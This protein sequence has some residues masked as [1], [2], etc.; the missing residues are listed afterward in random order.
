[1]DGA[2]LTPTPTSPAMMGAG[3]TNHVS[4]P[5]LGFPSG[6][7][8][9]FSSS[10]SV[11]AVSS[12]AATTGTNSVPFASVA[13]AAAALLSFLLLP[14]LLLLLVNISL[15]LPFRCHPPS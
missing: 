13:A 7:L 3:T 12:P 9:C 14:L 4:R 15:I 6:G 11:S 8:P 2:D 5:T 10:Y 1:M